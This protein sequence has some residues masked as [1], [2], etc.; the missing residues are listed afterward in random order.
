MTL[1]FGPVSVPAPPGW[2]STDF[3]ARTTYRPAGRCV[4]AAAVLRP[5][6]VCWATV[7]CAAWVVPAEPA[8]P[9]AAP[10]RAAGCAPDGIARVPTAS[11]AAAAIPVT[12]TTRVRSWRCR[13]RRS[14]SAVGAERA[15]RS[16]VDWIISSR[17]MSS[18]MSGITDLS[19]HC[20]GCGVRKKPAEARV[21]AQLRHGAGQG[22]PDGSR[23]DAEQFGDLVLAAVVEVAQHDD[24]P[25]V[26]RQRAERAEQHRPQ[27]DRRCRIGR[28]GI[29]VVMPLG[30]PGLRYLA[31]LEPTLVDHDVVHHPPAERPR[32]VQARPASGKAVQRL[33]I[34]VF[35]KPAIRGEKRRQSQQ[36]IT[37]L[38]YELLESTFLLSVHLAS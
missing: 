16:A 19:R 38:G 24:F 5:Y 37:G 11:P 15:N 23:C 35:A 14:A 8:E 4:A 21:L 22:A 18:S 9:A 7:S 33:L 2:L 30:Q 29:A 20:V 12:P 31:P 10:G 1:V 13:R 3:S 36:C 27:L 25:L 6:S 32:V 26:R 34:D 28:P 17:M